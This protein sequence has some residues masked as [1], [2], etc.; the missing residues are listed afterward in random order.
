MKK[1]IAGVLLLVALLAGG[2][3]GY[4]HYTAGETDSLQASGTIEATEVALSAK[5][6]G[7]LQDITVKTGD[8]VKEGQLV[9]TIVRNDLLAQK[10]RDELGVIKARA[11]YQ[12][13]ASG[14]RGQEI[15]EAEIMV[16]TASVNLDK[17][18]KDY[19]RN[20]SLHQ[21]GVLSI[22]EMER[23][24]TAL[25]QYTNQL[26]SAQSKLSL[27]KSGSR[28]GQIEAARAELER[29]EAVLKFSLAQLEDT[30]I[31]S[32]LEGTVLTRSFEAGEFVQAGARVATVANLKDMWIKVYIATDDLPGIKLGQ[33]VSFT[34]SGSPEIYKGTVEE[35]ASKGEF[36]PKAIQTK[37]ERTNIVYGVKIR[38]SSENG[39]L[40][41][42]MPA[43]VTFAKGDI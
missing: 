41:P 19:D 40:K 17:A 29:N 42:G 22:S 3:W 36:T 26:E 24:E 12:D 14:A 18:Q 1:K 39:V 37:K 6:A 31:I 7:T 43:D 32:P 13:M 21:D 16:N 23:S 35:I 27:L 30:K 33:G 8:T 2:Y 4:S 10:E 28:P 34:V 25:K 11:L 15:K 9:A 20:L 38:I 5:L